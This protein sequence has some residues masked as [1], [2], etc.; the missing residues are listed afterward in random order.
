M[1]GGAVVRG[2]P[3]SQSLSPHLFRLLLHTGA[4]LYA[5][6][7]SLPI[8]AGVRVK[9]RKAHGAMERSR[10]RAGRPP[11]SCFFYTV[12]RFPISDFGRLQL[13]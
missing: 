2:G 9:F 5:T 7:C 10:R 4:A 6:D 13:A 12:I 8:N 3:A 1:P 11:P